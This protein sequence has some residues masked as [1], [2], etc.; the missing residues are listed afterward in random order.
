MESPAT[1]TLSPTT[2]LFHALWQVEPDPTRC[3]NAAADGFVDISQATQE[4]AQ[5]NE[6]ER[7]LY[8]SPNS[9]HVTMRNPLYN[10]VIQQ[11]P[12]TPA[13]GRT[14]STTAVYGDEDHQDNLDDDKEVQNL[15]CPPRLRAT[16]PMHSRGTTK[17]PKREP[18]K[19][20]ASDTS[21]LN[22]PSNEPRRCY[23]PTGTSGVWRLPETSTFLESMSRTFQFLITLTYAWC[24]TDWI[25]LLAPQPKDEDIRYVVMEDLASGPEKSVQLVTSKII[26][27]L[28]V[29]AKLADRL[30]LRIYSVPAT[31]KLFFA[32]ECGSTLR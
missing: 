15:L 3:R 13:F 19:K 5:D 29:Q 23:S 27:E 2:T 31:L 20:M 17:S 11:G 14:W 1:P 4:S 22:D 6:T 25:S 12:G 9:P 8:Q 28:R 7:M 18:R 30:E 21:L 10:D 16:A 26:D 24:C 32:L